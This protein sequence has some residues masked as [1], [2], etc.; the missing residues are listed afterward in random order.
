[1]GRPIDSSLASPSSARAIGQSDRE[2]FD[3]SMAEVAD[4]MDNHRRNREMFLE[5]FRRHMVPMGPP[6]PPPPLSNPYARAVRGLH[7]ERVQNRYCLMQVREALHWLEGMEDCLESAGH[8]IDYLASMAPPPVPPEVPR[9]TVARHAPPS[10][11]TAAPPPARFQVER[12]RLV[13]GMGEDDVESSGPTLADI[14][15]AGGRR[16]ERTA[17]AAQDASGSQGGSDAEGPGM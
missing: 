2:R 11:G 15:A 7:L 17:V 12:V 16:L 5:R 1:M 14:R 13:R 6:G 3:A 9:A 4:C 10:T 8:M